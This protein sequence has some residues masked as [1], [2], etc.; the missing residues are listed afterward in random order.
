MLSVR[1]QL[2]LLLCFKRKIGIQEL[3]HVH[4]RSYYVTLEV[5]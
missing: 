4:T 1:Y 5:T 2:L 3:K